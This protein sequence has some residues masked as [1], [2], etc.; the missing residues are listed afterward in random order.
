[1]HYNPEWM[2]IMAESSAEDVAQETEIG[3]RRK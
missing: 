2:T 3:I 1:M